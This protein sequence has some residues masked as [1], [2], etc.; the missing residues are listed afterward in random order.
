MNRLKRTK[1]ISILLTAFF[2]SSLLTPPAANAA[3]TVLPK[4]GQCFQYTKAQVSASY[5]PKNP[6]NCS[7]THNMETFAVETW[8]LDENPVDMDREFTLD[9]V[10]ELCD[11]W[12]TF[13]NAAN[14]R[15][16]TSSFN[17][18]AW[19]TPSRA[20]WAKGQRWVRCDAMIGKFTAKD[21]WPPA[22]HTSWKGLKL[23]K[24]S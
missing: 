19:Y 4:V 24:Y 15:N 17:Y 10:N 3:Y 12:G 22:I 16:S 8:P 18:W 21:Q 5:A 14:S 20:A 1:I 23:Y 11:F 7:L 9:I 13:P 2:A 6:I